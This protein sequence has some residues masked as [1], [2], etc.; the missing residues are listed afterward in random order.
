MKK[1]ILNHKS[2]LL[3]DEIIKYKKDLSKIKSN[4][5]EFV[6]FPSIQYL[7]LFKDYNHKVGTQN[8]YSYNKGSYTGEINLESLK[9]MNIDY[10]LIGYYERKKIM[11]EEYIETKE[12][13]YRSLKSKFNTILCIGETN[14]TTKPFSQIK[15]ELNYYLKS[16]EHNKLKYLKIAYTPNYALREADLEIDKI[17]IIID[18]IRKYF[19][20]R[21]NIKIE[22]YYG[23]N[24][25]NS[26]IKEIYNYCDGLL[27]D[28]ESID[29]ELMKELLKEI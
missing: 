2:Y 17:K 10:T 29:I 24:I 18:K 26:N 11:H 23:G 5:Y 22:I 25:E 9:D 16:I 21:F 4:D 12:K 6:V 28:K 19:L 7:S 20:D 3:Y 1:I 15:R 27:L 14:K 13:L 8:F